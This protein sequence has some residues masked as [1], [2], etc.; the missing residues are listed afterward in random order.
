MSQASTT[1]NS[2][3]GGF[4]LFGAVVMVTVGLFQLLQGIVALVND[5]FYVVGPEYVYQFDLTT[6]GW[7][8]LLIGVILLVVG[9]FLF[10]GAGWARWTGI[11]IAVLSALSNFMWLPYYP[12]WSLTLIALDIV[13]IWALAVYQEPRQVA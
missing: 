13:V 1:R 9:G 10:T 12:F 2:W 4:M 5:K 11:A 7:I 3:A 8:H 6:W